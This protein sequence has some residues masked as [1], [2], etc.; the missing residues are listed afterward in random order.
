MTVTTKNSRITLPSCVGCY[1]AGL[2]TGKLTLQSWHRRLSFVNG[3][4]P[5]NV[6]TIPLL[7]GFGAMRID[8]QW[9]QSVTGGAMNLLKFTLPL[10]FSRNNAV[11]NSLV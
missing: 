7:G 6:Y 1:A 8:P 9:R 4:G 3:C 10:P 2:G 5:R 11:S